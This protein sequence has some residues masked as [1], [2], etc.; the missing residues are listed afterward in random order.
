[1]PRQHAGKLLTALARSIGRASAIQ[2]LVWMKQFLQ[3]TK[4]PNNSHLEA[5]LRRRISGEPLQ[6][7]LGTA[8]IL[9][10]SSTR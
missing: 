4:S 1:M 6:Y 10:T 2:E 3:S 8:G 5:M 7:I 9:R